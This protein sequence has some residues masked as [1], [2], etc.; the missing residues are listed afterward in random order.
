MPAVMTPP[1]PTASPFPRTK[2]WTVA[3]FHNVRESGVWDGL[4]TLLIRGTIWEQGP[5]NPPHANSVDLISELLRSAFGSQFRVRCQLPL[6][7]GF[8]TD[9]MPD[10][11]VVRGGVRN[12]AT[13]HPTTADLVV[14]VADT[15][16]YQ[17]TTT[18]AELYAEAGIQEYWVVDVGQSQ[19]IVFRD[20]APISIG[21]FHYRSKKTLLKTDT[22]SPLALPGNTFLIADLL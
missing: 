9:P 21:G 11:A 2:A 6:V 19:L 8:D 20:P 1:K 7:L 12:F 4:R 3:D 18:K 10:V 17:D 22:V 15:T 14:E 13:A 16:L 5:M